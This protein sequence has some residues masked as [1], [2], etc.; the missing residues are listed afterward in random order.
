MTQPNG[1]ALD[2]AAT[3]VYWTNIGRA[4]AVVTLLLVSYLA[5]AIIDVQ[6]E[7][8]VLTATISF[9]MSDRYRASDAARD[10]KLRDLEID[11][12]KA[13]VTELERLVRK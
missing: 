7:V 1:G 2:R 9:G 6:S 5:K 11:T 13:R 3:N 10:F 4:A 8:R 12:I